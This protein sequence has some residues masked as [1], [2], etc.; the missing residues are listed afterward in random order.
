[1]RSFVI[2]RILNVEEGWS[3]TVTLIN[4]DIA[5]KLMK[6]MTVSGTDNYLFL[7]M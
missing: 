3:F 5:K 4:L 2:F 6:G 1:M 7:N